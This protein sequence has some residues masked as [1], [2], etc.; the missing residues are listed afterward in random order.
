MPEPT[1]EFAALC[2]RSALT[3]ALQYKERFHMSTSPEDTLEPK[4]PSQQQQYLLWSQQQDNNFCNP[5]KPISLESLEKLLQAI[6][7]AHSFVSLRLGDQVTALEMAIQLLQ[8][9]RLSDAHK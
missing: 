3:L 7:A 6:Y 9:E 1:L 2:L 4:D 5:S 8:S